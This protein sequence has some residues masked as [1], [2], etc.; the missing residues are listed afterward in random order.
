MI[1]ESSN[2]ALVMVSSKSGAI[3]DGQFPWPKNVQ[4]FIYEKL[5]VTSVY[6]LSVRVKTTV[7]F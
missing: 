5:T 2:I 1:A 4:V 6:P 3:L 7:K